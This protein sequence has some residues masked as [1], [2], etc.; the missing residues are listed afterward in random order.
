MRYSI[1]RSKYQGENI[2]FKSELIDSKL[3]NPK[4]IINQIVYISEL[5]KVLIL[6]DGILSSLNF[7][8]LEPA[9]NNNNLFF[10]IKNVTLF[11]FSEKYKENAHSFGGDKSLLCV[12]IKSRLLQ[13]YSIDNNSL[14][15]FRE[16]NLTESI[17]LQIEINKSH[18]CV[19]CDNA[20]LV[21][22]IKTAKIQTLFSYEIDH[23]T[24]PHIVNHVDG[25]FLLN[26]QG[27]LG[28]FATYDGKTTR[29]PITWCENCINFQ[30]SDPYVLCATSDSIKVYNLIDSK[31]KQEI[32][33]TQIKYMDYIEDENIIFLC[34]P[35]RVCALNPY[36]PAMQINQ[37]LESKRV[38]E[39]LDLFELLNKKL[40]S[41][42]YEEV[43]MYFFSLL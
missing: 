40:N 15:L 21:I 41:S 13:L 25:E 6:S 43:I 1:N 22:D 38:D 31:L 11:C 14:S 20:Y 16:I 23:L 29:P 33:Y 2:G 12:C 32:E 34:T 36:S 35:T 17:C 4:K 26:C 30:I 7:H 10:R 19:A 9:T 5:Q 42:E 27:N 37:L 18:M 8:D 39:A 3:I 28:M 24:P